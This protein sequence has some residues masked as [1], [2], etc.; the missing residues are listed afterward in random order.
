[1]NCYK[2]LIITAKL[3]L[4]FILVTALAII[5]AASLTVTYTRR[6]IQLFQS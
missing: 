5:I 3:L 1:M 4:G 2:N 6:A